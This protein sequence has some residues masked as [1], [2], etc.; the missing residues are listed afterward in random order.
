MERGGRSCFVELRT[1]TVVTDWTDEP[2]MGELAVAGRVSVVAS[3]C[4][5]CCL[6]LPFH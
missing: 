5:L 1:L 4:L 6:N 3:D 2:A